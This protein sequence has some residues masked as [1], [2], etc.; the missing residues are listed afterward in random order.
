MAQKSFLFLIL[1]VLTTQIFS[2]PRPQFA[3]SVETNL[4]QV[5]KDSFS[6]Y[7]SYRIPYSELIFSKENSRFVSGARFISE[8]FE[9]DNLVERKSIDEQISVQSYPETLRDSLFIQSIIEYKLGKSK[10]LIKP[11]VFRNNTDTELPLKE[12]ELDLLYNERK[13]KPIV[14]MSDKGREQFTLVNR[15]HLI[16]YDDRQ[17]N[18]MVP[19]PDSVSGLK[20]KLEQNKAPLLDT[21]ITT[22]KSGLWKIVKADDRIDMKFIAGGAIQPYSYISILL[23]ITIDEGDL[24]VIV[25]NQKKKTIYNVP[26]V[27]LNKP[28]VLNDIDLSIKLLSFIIDAKRVDSLQSRP[29]AMQYSSL[30][31][32]WNKII[33]P[34][35]G[36]LNMLMKEFYSRADFASANYTYNG[37]LNGALSDRGKIYIQFGKPDK[38]DRDYY[39]KNEITEIWYYENLKREFIFEDTTGKGNYLLRK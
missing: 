25:E 39:N 7:I 32:E 27:W 37:K 23:P 9:G 8:I 24:Q 19:I 31:K 18:L 29:S 33:P 5:S 30:K 22:V 35:A 11:S 14:I 28:L 2:Q 6:L 12:I 13:Q 20:V 34:S 4:I 1:I 38:I 10:Y 26:V 3:G 17:Y 15:G 16:P 21:L 36:P